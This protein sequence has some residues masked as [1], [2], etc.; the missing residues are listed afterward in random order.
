M[1]H[2]RQT[3]MEGTNVA[4]EIFMEIH[5]ED[6]IENI[7]FMVSRSREFAPLPNRHLQ[8]MKLHP[9]EKHLSQV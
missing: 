8:S 2:I 5:I 3:N 7:N 1:G 4:R 9:L 6:N